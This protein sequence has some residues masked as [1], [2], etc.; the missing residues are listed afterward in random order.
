MIN[1]ELIAGIHKKFLALPS[2]NFARRW[3]S[4]LSIFI[5]KKINGIQLSTSQLLLITKT[6]ISQKNCSLLIFGLGNDSL[7]WHHINNQ[8]NTLF[9]EDNNFWL[10]K[11][12][13]RNREIKAININYNTKRKQWRYLLENPKLL[14]IDLPAEIKNEKWDIILVD[15]PAGYADDTPGRMMS[16]YISHKLVKPGKHV[17]VHDCN[18]EV[19]D[20]YSLKFLGKENLKQEIRASIGYLRHFIIPF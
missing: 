9:L 16:I 4:L 5:M 8:G 14:E 19:E 2:I 17:F 20:I 7:F 15:A 1:N 3:P 13:A 12:T 11:V 18:R 10:E 6:I